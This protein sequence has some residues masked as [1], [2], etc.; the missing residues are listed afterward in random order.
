MVSSSL[1]ITYFYLVMASGKKNML[2]WQLNY[3]LS[4]III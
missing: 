2:L 3:E 4:E 1:Q